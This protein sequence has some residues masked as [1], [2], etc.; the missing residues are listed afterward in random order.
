M[1]QILIKKTNPQLSQCKNNASFKSLIKN[2]YQNLSKFLPI[3][4]SVGNKAV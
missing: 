1:Q 2:N 4:F 3:Y